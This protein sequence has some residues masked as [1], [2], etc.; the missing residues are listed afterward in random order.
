MIHDCE[1][2]Y[3]I[4]WSIAI[5]VNIKFMEI[6]QIIA[7]YKIVKVLFFY[8]TG[9]SKFLVCAWYA[10]CD[11]KLP[12]K[13]DQTHKKYHKRNVNNKIYKSKT[14]ARINYRIIKLS[15]AH[16]CL[17]RAFL[18]RAYIKARSA[19]SYN[20]FIKAWQKMYLINRWIDSFYVQK[21]TS[22]FRT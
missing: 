22:T 19:W 6:N 1:K 14:H 21:I 15:R 4:H 9:C 12:L 10:L 17:F 18:S 7:S 3:N 11:L 8:H 5:S 16:V 2:I 13:F 20:A